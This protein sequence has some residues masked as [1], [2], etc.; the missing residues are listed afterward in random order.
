VRSSLAGL[1]TLSLL[2]PA[3]A[4]AQA[5][6]SAAPAPTYAAPP[7]TPAPTYTAPPAP[8]PTYTAPPATPAPTYTAPPVASP[9]PQYAPPASEAAPASGAAVS[10][11]RD[12]PG[13]SSAA[14]KEPPFYRPSSAELEMAPPAPK[15]TP[16]M[17]SLLEGTDDFV[18]GSVRGF[19][20][21][22]RV[23]FGK[24]IGI[25]IGT[26]NFNTFGGGVDFFRYAGIPIDALSGSMFK[27]FVLLPN[28]DARVYASGAKVGA[29]IGTAATGL[30]LANCALTGC[31]EMSLRVLSVDV[32]GVS[33]YNQV[34]AAVSIGGNL[35]VGMK[36]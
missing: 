25:T 35:S 6:P 17:F 3:V 9:P 33:D 29:A 32:W 27:V 19:G 34:S 31:F 2:V 4:F 1:A 21:E 36:L 5:A 7:A 28:L 11:D 30:R 13:T 20:D 24:D 10:E 23:R 16:W 15:T 18:V 22:T 26:F 14:P 12:G 8:A